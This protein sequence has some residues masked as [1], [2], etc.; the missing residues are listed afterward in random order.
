MKI[1]QIGLLVAGLALSLAGCSSDNSY[2]NETNGE[3]VAT[4]VT[5]GV[6]GRTLHT[7]SSTGADSTFKVNVQG[8]LYPM[9]I[10]QL[11]H[12]IYNLDSLPVGTDVKHVVFSAFTTTGWTSIKTLGTRK[13]TLFSATD[14][15]DFSVPREITVYATDGVSSRTYTV[16][17]RVHRQWPDSATWTRLVGSHALL[18]ATTRQRALNVD[19]TF[20]AFVLSD[21]APALLTASGSRPSDWTSRRIDRPDLEVRSVVHFKG[22]FYALAGGD[23]VTSEDGVTWTADES[24]GVPQGTQALLAAGTDCLAAMADGKM[25]SSQD[26]GITWQEDAL[27]SEAA[28]LPAPEEAACV[29]LGSAGDEWYENL[30]LVGTRQG[31]ARVWK[32]DID[33]MEGTVHPWVYFP[34]LEENDYACPALKDATLLPYDGGTLLLG[35]TAA[36]GLSPF[37]LSKDNGRTWNSSLLKAPAFG[38]VTGVAA[39][40]DADHYI[41]VFCSGTGDIWRGRINRLGWADEPSSFTK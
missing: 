1:F 28:L 31:T 10:D 21:G 33:L 29:R 12:R 6:L 24:L 37:Y 3:C 25:Y 40:V 18:A 35:M 19:G 8:A 7:L 39:T 9:S 36:G 34:P 38:N 2:D 17:V 26:A 27:D 11:N 41:Y 16:D 30:L 13:D 23:L 15:T 5:L 4:G 20:Y 32:R 22:R 14:S